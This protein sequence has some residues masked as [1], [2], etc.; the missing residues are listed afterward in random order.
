MSV[1]GDYYLLALRANFELDQGLRNE[2][3]DTA[4]TVLRTH[5]TSTTPRIWALC[6]L[7]LVRAR[8]GDPGFPELL[9]EAAE[10]AEPT[11]ELSRVVP[12]AGAR[13][14]TAWLAGDVDGVA[15][16]TDAV[17]SRAR[18]LGD[19]RVLGQLGS[20]RRLAGL[21]AEVATSAPEPYRL[22]LEGAWSEAATAWAERGCHYEAGIARAQTG[23]EQELLQALDELQSMGAQPATAIVARRLRELGVRGVSRGPRAATRSNPANLTGRELEVL[24][25]LG[26]NLTNAEIAEHLVLSRRTVEHHVSAILRKLS[27]Q[28]R[29]Q[30]G[31]EALRLGLVGEDAS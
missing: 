16:A 8:R 1:P 15:D 9:A 2:A 24:V 6:V 21:D 25:L 17:R 4:E 5:R 19:S 10:L 26:R 22:Q 27:V 14:E 18:D 3:A 7:A 30:A 23:E 12:V 13:A 28:T 20:W 31:A 29:A 11:G